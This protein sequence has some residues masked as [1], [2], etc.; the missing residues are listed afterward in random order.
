MSTQ[1]SSETGLDYIIQ[2]QLVSYADE[3]AV[4]EGA[5]MSFF[6]GVGRLFEKLHFT[7]H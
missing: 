6:V 2:A 1:I 3:V 5:R 4:G 7:L